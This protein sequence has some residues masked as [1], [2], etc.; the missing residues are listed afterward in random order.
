M[1]RAQGRI[2]GFRIYSVGYRMIRHRRNESDSKEAV[3]VLRRQLL[4]GTFLEVLKARGR[5]PAEAAS[6]PVL[7]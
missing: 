4:P 5:S 6:I 2:Q 1:R 7:T 3:A